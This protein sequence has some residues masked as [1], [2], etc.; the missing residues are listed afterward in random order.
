[1][2]CRHARAVIGPRHR[3]PRL[4]VFY[5]FSR[6]CAATRPRITTN[7]PFR[8]RSARKRTDTVYYRPF[9]NRNPPLS[10]SFFFF[11][12]FFF[13]PSVNSLAFVIRRWKIKG[14]FSFVFFFIF[15]FDELDLNEMFLCMDVLEIRGECDW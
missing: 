12:F 14:G 8:N 1:M 13:P 11:L 5:W 15:S 2:S 7:I 9:V 3:Y 6:P 10:V 4:S